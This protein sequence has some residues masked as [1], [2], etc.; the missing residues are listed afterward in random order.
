MGNTID[1]LKQLIESYFGEV[2]KTGEASV[3]VN[4][5]IRDLVITSNKIVANVVMTGAE[6]TEFVG[7]GHI[8]NGKRH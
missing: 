6:L 2:R 5:E 3:P 7:F 8:E 4:Y 1:L